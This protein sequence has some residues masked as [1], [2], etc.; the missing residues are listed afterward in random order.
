MKHGLV[1]P[2]DDYA[3][4]AIA[5]AVIECIRSKVR[6]VVDHGPND[7]CRKQF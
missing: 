5:Q 6:Y 2:I 1:M 7:S 4:F 3:L